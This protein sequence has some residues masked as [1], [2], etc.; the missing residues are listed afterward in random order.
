MNQ[1][2]THLIFRAYIAA[3]RN[4][5]WWPKQVNAAL[6]NADAECSIVWDEW[7]EIAKPIY[8]VFG[9]TGSEQFKRGITRQ[10]GRIENLIIC[11]DLRRIYGD[12]SDVKGFD[13][14]GVFIRKRYNNVLIPQKQGNLITELVPYSTRQLV[15]NFTYEY[16]TGI[17]LV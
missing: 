16:Q 13:R 4:E 12:L 14:D 17:D 8:D 10:P 9:Y 3:A 6:L 11:A 7:K 5:Q 1:K 2:L 15:K